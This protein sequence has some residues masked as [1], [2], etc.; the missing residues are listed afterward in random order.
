MR[1]QEITGDEGQVAAF[2]AGYNGA[3]GFPLDGAYARRCRAYA[4]MD[5][6]DMNGGFLLNPQPP[7]RAL[8]DMPDEDRRRILARLDLDQTFE[9]MCLWMRPA[10]RGGFRMMRVWATVLYVVWRF[11]RRDF[12][13]CAVVRSLKKQYLVVHADVIYEGT[14]ETPDRVFDKYVLLVRGKRG[15]LR[16]L[17][18]ET[19]RRLRRRMRARGSAPGSRV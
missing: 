3:G 2:V 8:N 7:F 1:L 19:L 13:T 6:A 9:G 11:P 14:I 18:L 16:G 5:G 15:F 17:A 10:V 12:L 4:F